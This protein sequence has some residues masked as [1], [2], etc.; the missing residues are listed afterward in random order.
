MQFLHLLV[1]T[2]C[3]VSRT[4]HRR[5]REG[6]QVDRRLASEAGAALLA[7]ESGIGIVFNA[8][9]QAKTRQ[10]EMRDEI[11]RRSSGSASH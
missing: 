5:N 9:I 10:P 7:P 6:R 1:I 4:D 2:R 3:W 11:E 8:S